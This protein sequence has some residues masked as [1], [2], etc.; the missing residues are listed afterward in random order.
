MSGE[1]ERGAGLADLGER[2]PQ[3]PACDRVHPGRRLV[4]KHDVRFGDQRYRRA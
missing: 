4:E 1:D 3:V 2:V